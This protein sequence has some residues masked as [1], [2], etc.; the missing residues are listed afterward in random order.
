MC[1]NKTVRSSAIPTIVFTLCALAG[2]LTA[3]RA[4]GQ[5]HDGYDLYPLYNDGGADY[6]D[7][8]PTSRDVASD[9]L[10]SGDAV[11]YVRF[12]AG[13]VVPEPVALAHLIGLG[14][15]TVLWLWWRRSRRR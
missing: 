15:G 3:E 6:L 12:P 1:G 7:P 4:F 9:P 14:L 13:S 10:G 2:S 5:V 11:G 8:V